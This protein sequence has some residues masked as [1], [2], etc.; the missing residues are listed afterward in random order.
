MLD[1]LPEIEIH[2][3]VRL[4]NWVLGIKREMVKARHNSS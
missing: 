2:N 4:S 1:K 3:T